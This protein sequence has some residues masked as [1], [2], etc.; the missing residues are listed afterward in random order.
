MG[1]GHANLAAP[2]AAAVAADAALAA[3]AA[4]RRPL[5]Q[6]LPT[7]QLDLH[8]GDVAFQRPLGLAPG[9]H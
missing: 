4:A 1:S 6:W 2:V 7:R 5:Q 3:Q 9:A 8:P